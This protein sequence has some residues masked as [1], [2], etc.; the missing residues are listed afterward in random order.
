MSRLWW[1]LFSLWVGLTWTASAFAAEELKDLLDRLLAV[2]T[3][4]TLYQMT[5]AGTCTP[6]LTI[7][8]KQWGYPTGLT[9]TPDGKTML[10]GTAQP[11]TGDPAGPPKSMSANRGEVSL[12]GAGSDEAISVFGAEIASLRSQ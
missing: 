9:F 1:N 7:D 6:F 2:P 3:I 5:P 12:R 4:Q 11:A 8:I 10:I